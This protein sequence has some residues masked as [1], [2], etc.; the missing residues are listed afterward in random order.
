[1]QG[2]RQRADRQDRADH[3]DDPERHRQRPQRSAP[4]PAAAPIA[5]PSPALVSPA[6]SVRTVL[7]LGVLG[8]QPD[9]VVAVAGGL[10]VG[11]RLSAAARVANT[12]TWVVHV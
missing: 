7:P 3:R 2:R 12:P 4:A 11:D 1:M 5:A 6:P 8:D 10:Q 9:L